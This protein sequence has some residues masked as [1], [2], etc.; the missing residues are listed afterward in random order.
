M[1]TNHL[2]LR[3]LFGLVVLPIDLIAR[4]TV[5]IAKDTLKRLAPK[6]HPE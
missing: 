1:R 3:P 4:S 2:L 5:Q 6:A